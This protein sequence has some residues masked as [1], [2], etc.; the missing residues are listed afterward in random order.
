MKRLKWACYFTNISMAVAGNLPPILFLTFRS[1]YGVSYSLLGLLVLP[2][3]LPELSQAAS[4]LIIMIT[5]S[6]RA[7]IFFIDLLPFFLLP[8]V[9]MLEADFY[10]P[11]NP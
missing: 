7:K 3:L 9:F 4:M 2:E 11:V 1:M 5:A 10:L 6:R 8:L